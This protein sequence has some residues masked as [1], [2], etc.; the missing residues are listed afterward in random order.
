M[1]QLHKSDDAVALTHYLKPPYDLKFLK[2]R[3]N[4][5]DE[6]PWEKGQNLIPVSS[7]GFIKP[8]TET[9]NTGQTICGHC[10]QQHKKQKGK[11][12][13]KRWKKQCK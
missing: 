8:L 2:E 6:L 9:M 12:K 3:K 5:L 4:G 13:K 1:S 11:K 7:E 10:L